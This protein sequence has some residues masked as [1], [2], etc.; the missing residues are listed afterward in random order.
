[1]LGPARVESSNVDDL[2]GEKVCEKRQNDE[3]Q[4]QPESYWCGNDAKLA[5]PASVPGERCIKK[6]QNST[7][8]PQQ[9]DFQALTKSRSRHGLA[10]LCEG[11]S[12]SRL[13]QKMPLH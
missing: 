2:L 3:H 7:W 13:Q 10:C 12:T 11:L 1:M 9:K 4:L 8:S 5:G 6:R